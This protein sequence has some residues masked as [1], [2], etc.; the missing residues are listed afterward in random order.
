MPKIENWGIRQHL[1]HRMRDRAIS[2]AD[3]NELRVRRAAPKKTRI[4]NLCLC[5]V[6]HAS[7]CALP[8]ANRIFR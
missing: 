6:A 1:I 2:V 5:S 7:V 3:L 4:T 8:T